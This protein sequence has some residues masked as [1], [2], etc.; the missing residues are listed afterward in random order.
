[1]N[2]VIVAAAG[3]GKTTYLVKRALDLAGAGKRVLITT[4]TEACCQ[5]LKDKFFSM[6]G[7]IPGNV[8]IR[9]WFSFL[10]ECGV[11]PYQGNLFEFDCNG[12]IL[13]NGKSGLRFYGKNGQ[14]IYWGEKDFDRYFFT[15]ARE[16][17]SDK[18]ALLML[19]CNEASSDQVFNRISRCFD[20]IFVD[21]VQDLAGYDLE[22]LDELFKLD[23]DILLVGDPR[24]GTYSTSNTRKNKKFAKAQIVE[25]FDI[26]RKDLSIDDSTLMVN[27][28]CTKELVDL[29]NLLYPEFPPASSGNFE[30]TSHDGIFAVSRKDITRYL[31]EHENITQLRERI[32]T[33]VDEN[34]PA[35]NFGKSKGLT[36]K[37]ALIYPSGPMVQWL[38]NHDANISRS[39]RSKLYVALTRA[40]FS[41]GIVLDN[42]VIDS[43]NYLK[44][45]EG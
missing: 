33:S 43:I 13:V 28:R 24:Q 45:Y 39:A 37:R 32:T 26:Q 36:F 18:L 14:P 2:K 34:Y 16:I 29:S 27:H 8:V 44:R 5:E 10:I 17:Y 7:S 25:Y 23:S 21:E 9:G 11:K 40:R 42:K 19:R 41:V 3:A 30:S 22:I 1:M 38:K 6:N 35:L 15:S 12:M 31:S 20:A 4:F